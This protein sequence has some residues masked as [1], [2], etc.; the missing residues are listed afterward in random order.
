MTLLLYVRRKRWD[1]KSIAVE[2]SRRR[3]N[4]EEGPKEVFDQAIHVEGSLTT[5]QLE[6]I[7]YIA[8]RC[9]MHRTLE[10]GPVITDTVV[11][12]D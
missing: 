2:S 8:G 1:V 12:V 3:V 5:D 4:T 6:R 11:L 7:K 10:S 9:P